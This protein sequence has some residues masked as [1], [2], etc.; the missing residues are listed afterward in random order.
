MFFNYYIQK[1]L[2]VEF[3]IM[4]PFEHLILFR[5]YTQVFLPVLDIKKVQANLGTD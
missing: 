2:E 5:K 3:D 4:V 1:Y